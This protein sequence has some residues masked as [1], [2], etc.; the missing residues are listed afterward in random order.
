[1]R[2]L[3]GSRTASYAGGVCASAKFLELSQ[4]GHT[5]T[6]RP[7]S[8][9]RPSE[10]RLTRHSGH[11]VSASIP[12]KMPDSSAEGGA[13]VCVGM[14]QT[15]LRYRV[16]V[17]LR[18]LYYHLL[19]LGAIPRVGHVIT[20]E[21]QRE[22]LALEAL[23]YIRRSHPSWA[24]DRIWLDDEYLEFVLKSVGGASRFRRH[25]AATTPRLK[26]ALMRVSRGYPQSARGFT[27]V[28]EESSLVRSVLAGRLALN[29]P[30]ERYATRPRGT[31]SIYFECRAR[32]GRKV[33]IRV[34]DHPPDRRADETLIDIS[35][36][37]YS[38][39]SRWFLRR[40]DELGIN[41]DA[42]DM[43]G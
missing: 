18:R 32:D 16:R 27:S 3:D 26:A 35:P 43:A 36:T 17:R 9:Y 37:G 12:S 19:T 31:P 7:S 30:R 22:R 13:A 11:S 8:R 29:P 21:E 4:M 25:G 5:T 41:R 1:M 39:F 23:A 15:I 10:Y 2:G 28:A 14:G 38:A 20:T 42:Q 6:M 24:R 34:S 40:L 33:V